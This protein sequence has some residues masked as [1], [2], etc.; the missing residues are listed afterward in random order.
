VLTIGYVRVADHI[1]ELANAKVTARNF[2]GTLRVLDEI[3]AG[4]GAHRTLMHGQIVHGMQFEAPEKQD[5]PTAYY[6]E[7]SG[8]GR[9]LL[10]KAAMATSTAGK[11]ASKSL[12][13]GIIG[14]GIGTLVTYG[15]PGD[16]FRLYD[17]D[18][19]VVALARTEF[20]FLSRTKASTDTILG[21]AR[22]MMER[23]IPQQFDVL[24]VDA[25]SGDAVPI[26][27]LTR[28]AFAGYFKHLK[29]DGVL[30]V[31]VTNRFLD[32]NPVVKTAVESFDK[33][34]RLVT[35]KRD[36]SRLI[37]RSNWVLASADREFFAH[38]LIHE[39]AESIDVRPGF[40]LWRDDYSSVLAVLK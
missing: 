29:P 8:V 33:V 23:E 22:L 13:V 17:I 7:E 16:Y 26:H 14:V 34:A 36:S 10:A 38:S 39:V 30:V 28:E 21:D 37:F 32:L 5:V 15:R 31:H 2:Y 25:F 12:R 20:S 27:L 24:V 11:S 6:S 40:R 3:T 18:P 19:L 1:D 4:A 35:L 9:T